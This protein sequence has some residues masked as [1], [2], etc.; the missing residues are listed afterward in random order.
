M[1]ELAIAPPAVADSGA[2]LEL[3]A[4]LGVTPDVLV[5]EIQGDVAT[6]PTISQAIDSWLGTISIRKSPKTIVT[7]QSGIRRLT[8]WLPSRG[9]DPTMAP[10]LVFTPLLF[11]DFL[12][13][14]T[15]QR[16]VVK[17]SVSVYAAAA[18]S[19]FK[20]LKRHHQ[21]ARGVLYEDVKLTASEVIGSVPYLTP[22]IPNDLS[23]IVD[24]LQRLETPPVQLRQWRGEAGKYLALLRDRAL[25]L[26]LAHTG[27]R[28]AEVV[29]LDRADVED[30]RKDSCLIVGKG[31]KERA[32]F[33]S[34]AAQEAIRAYCVARADDYQPLFIRHNRRG[35]P[36]GHHGELYRLETQS[37]WLSVQKYGKLVGVEAHPHAFRHAFASGMLQNGAQLP[38]IAQLLGHASVATTQRIYARL[39]TA[40]LRTA[41]EQYANR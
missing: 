27:M 10:T 19:F 7:Y 30:G 9:I 35:G 16:R 5:R 31:S 32:V 1:N 11:E 24:L 18:K 28:A 17:G 6:V 40:H 3:L 34:V 39:D 25:V 20:Y 15:Q 14:C 8:E 4:R 29:S 2:L 41:F 21:S 36:A 38:H 26:T 22:K 12:V 23:K 37:V 33:F 13:D